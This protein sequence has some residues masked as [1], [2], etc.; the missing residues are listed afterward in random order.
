VTERTVYYQE[1]PDLVHEIGGS[2]VLWQSEV[3]EVAGCAIRFWPALRKGLENCG[4]RVVAV[5]F[6]DCDPQDRR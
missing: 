5:D 6:A 4:Y 3:M 2:V 1:R